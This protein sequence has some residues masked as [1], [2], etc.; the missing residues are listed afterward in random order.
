MNLD[1]EILGN[2]ELK[3]R[4]ENEISAQRSEHKSEMQHVATL[5]MIF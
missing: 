5:T 2:D 3:F 4:I 1:D